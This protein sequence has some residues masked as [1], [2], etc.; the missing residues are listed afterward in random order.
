MVIIA[1]IKIEMVS[2]YVKERNWISDLDFNDKNELKDRI[3]GI[4]LNN[5][6]NLI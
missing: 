1:F 4:K 6:H 5:R 3:L 2:Y